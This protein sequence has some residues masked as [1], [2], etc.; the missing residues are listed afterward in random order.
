MVPD[1]PTVC[2][3]CG[4]PATDREFE[5]AEDGTLLR[6]ESRC[7]AHGG[8]P[9]AATRHSVSH[10][11][12]RWPLTCEWCKA[13][14]T[15]HVNAVGEGKRTTHHYCSEHAADAGLIARRAG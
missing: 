2:A 14:A 9:V 12:N 7:V 11:M 6:D 1:A 4:E 3:M 8:R 13:I 10:S 5:F 15:V